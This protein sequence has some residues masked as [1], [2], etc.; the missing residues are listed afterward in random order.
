MKLKGDLWTVYKE[1]C[2]KHGEEAESYIKGVST[3]TD[4][5]VYECDCKLK[6]TQPLLN[7]KLERC[8]EER[9]SEEIGLNEPG[10]LG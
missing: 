9:C 8:D 1:T 10:K 6:K 7:L 4:M 2:A 5:C 3:Q